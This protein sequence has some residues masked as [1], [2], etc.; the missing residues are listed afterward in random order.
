MMIVLTQWSI[1]HG[2]SYSI[3]LHGPPYTVCLTWYPDVV[4]CVLVRIMCR[5]GGVF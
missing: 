3:F 4:L 1:S 5:W 2:V